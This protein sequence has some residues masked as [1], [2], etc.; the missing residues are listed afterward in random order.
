[1]SAGMTSDRVLERLMRLHPKKIDLS[2]GRVERLL[3]RLGNP[4]QKLPPVVH[5]AGTN[6]KGST[7]AT[8]RACLEAAGYR[9]H[10]YISPHLVRFRERIRLA[11]RLIEE[12]RLTALLE[13]CE[14]ANRD[15]PITFFE[16]TTAAAFL[17]FA[18]T[19]ADVVLLEVGLG[20]R[21]DA[22]NVVRHPAVTAITP[23][24]LDH[25][26]FL[27]D[28]I[29]AIAGEKAGILK[30]G[31][32]AVIAPQP[33]E[34]AAVIEARAAAV[35]APL[36]RAGQEW[37]C[38]ASGSGMRYEGERW[39]F[40]LPLPSLI[41]AHQIVN[42]GTA[43]ACLER[44]SG[45]DVPNE[46]IVLGLH[47][48]DWPAR[49]Q[50]LRRGPLVDA[51]PPDWELWLDGGHNPAAGEVLGDVAAGWHDCP[52]YLVVGMMNTKDTAGF[53]APLARH[54]RALWA[55]T[56]PAEPNALPAE[57]ITDAAG[58]VGLPAKTAESV[59]A[60]IC[61]IPVHDGNSRVLIC[62]SLYFA[63][64]VLAENG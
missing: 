42:A 23:V 52:L 25:Q 27:G 29:A 60:A 41:G 31:V 58:S 12:E 37:H 50:L 57:A 46:A 26:S 54:A 62:G 47:K 24:S 44:L 3:A 45:F 13:E 38:R 28:T 2:L 33:G 1:M 6:G 4:E 48:I 17:A 59:L 21:L 30:P 5:V 56:I 15:A 36:Y 63:G 43:I 32:R 16:I 18:H 14:R 22:T 19:P 51:V 40:D 20:G 49:L 7:V 35:S 9:V 11:G 10:A 34:A 61:D 53:I 39:R 55:V 64:K 8:M